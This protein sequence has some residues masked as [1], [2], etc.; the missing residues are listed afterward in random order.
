MCGRIAVQYHL[1]VVVHKGLL[2][3]EKLAT[4]MAMASA[5]AMPSC[6]TMTDAAAS[7]IVAHF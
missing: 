1:R 4:F 7:A 5:A 6:S 3:G 2:N